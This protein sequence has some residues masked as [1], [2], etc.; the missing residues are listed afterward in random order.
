MNYKEKMLHQSGWPRGSWRPS[1]SDRPQS[2]SPHWRFPTKKKKRRKKKQHIWAS[3][4]IKG[5]KQEKKIVSN[6]TW[7]K[8]VNIKVRT[9]NYLIFLMFL[10]FLHWV[11]LCENMTN[12]FV[13]LSVN[14]TIFKCN[15]GT[16]LL[17]CWFA[18]KESLEVI[19]GEKFWY[20]Q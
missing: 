9:N 17:S 14:I 2:A 5:K 11:W 15:Y 12:F 13:Y 7:L 8:L 4:E 19:L 3:N 18:S 20:L 6:L 16:Q 10:Y 1:W